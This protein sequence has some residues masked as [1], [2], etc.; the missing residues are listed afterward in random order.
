MMQPVSASFH[1]AGNHLVVGFRGRVRMYQLLLDQLRVAHEITRKGGGEVKFSCGGNVFSIVSGKGVLVYATYG[2]RAA[3]VTQPALLGSF[4]GH[5]MPAVG[6]A[7]KHNG[8]G[9]VSASTD[10]AVYEWKLEQA[11]A[12]GRF[13]ELVRKDIAYT[14]VAASSEGSV[15]AA[16]KVNT[17][18]S[19]QS[20][21]QSSPSG[22]SGHVGVGVGVGVGSSSSRV[23]GALC[24][25]T[26]H[27]EGSLVEILAPC[28][29]TKLLLA[30]SNDL[31]FAGTCNGSVLVYRW[32]LRTP[33]AGG[34]DGSGG[35]GDCSGGGEDCLLAEIPLHTGAVTGLELSPDGGTLFSAAAD[36][37]LFMV[38]LADA[39]R[40]ALLS[41]KD[42]ARQ[43]SRKTITATASAESLSSSSSSSSSSS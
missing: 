16:G 4:L 35:G 31:L 7:W 42:K 40:P 24:S 30:P 14:A 19:K 2:D 29:C 38:E 9:L 1:P 22:P 27:V 43:S 39:H 17:Q 37:S 23:A 15:A 25:W 32:P 3:G 20:Q 33:A 21:P 28:L 10:G 5:S 11:G 18:L 41:I 6:L 13:K 36:G 34:G 26:E 8:L 12:G